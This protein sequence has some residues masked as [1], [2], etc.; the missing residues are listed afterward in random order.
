LVDDRW[1]GFRVTSH[2][3]LA[4]TLAG[5]MLVIG[6]AGLRRITGL[7]PLASGF[8]LAASLLIAGGFLV[9]AA[10]STVPITPVH[11]VANPLDTSPGAL[12]YAGDLYR[13][14]CAACHGPDGQGAG[15]ANA[16]HL[17]G[18]SA[19]LT[20]DQTTDQSDGDLRYWIENGVPGTR[21]PAFGSA[22]A[23]DE[24]WQLVLL[25]RQMQ[26]EARQQTEQE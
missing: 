10:R 8:L 21:M 11:S 20:R 26:E 19:D 23:E 1:G 12:T 17:H 24:Q 14:N 22:L 5:L 18:G 15:D 6:L 25:I 2:T 16:A 7:E 13:L 4:L 9:S 3:A